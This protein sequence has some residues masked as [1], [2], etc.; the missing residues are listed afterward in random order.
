MN[1]KKKDELT[2]LKNMNQLIY[3][4]KNMNYHIYKKY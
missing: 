2:L 4:Y 3:I 1:L